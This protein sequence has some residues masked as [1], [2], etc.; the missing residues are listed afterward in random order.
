[1]GKTRGEQEYEQAL[2]IQQTIALQHQHGAHGGKK[3][4]IA[5][6]M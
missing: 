1:M 5:Q 6:R 2:A 3:L 4:Q